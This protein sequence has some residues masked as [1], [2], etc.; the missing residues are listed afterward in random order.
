MKCLT[1]DKLLA[2]YTFD[3]YYMT[4]IIRIHFKTLLDTLTEIHNLM[5]Y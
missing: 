2:C 5:D 3:V 1:I 4:V